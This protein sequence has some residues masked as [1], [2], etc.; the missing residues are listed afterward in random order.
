MSTTPSVKDQPLVTHESAPVS[1]DLV[2]RTY[3]Y[4]GETGEKKLHV[5]DYI[6]ETRP[7]Y[8]V[9]HLRKL[10]FS[11]FMITLASTNAGFDGSLLNGLQSLSLWGSYMGDPTG[12]R[13][14]AIA[15]GYTFGCILSFAVAAWLNDRIGRVKTMMFGSFWVAVGG[16]LQGATTS[17]TTQGA[18]AM[19]LIAR[20]IMGF[21]GAIASVAAPTLLSEISYPTHREACT[22]SY[23]ICWY[24]GASICAIVTYITKEISS[25]WQWR[26]PAVLQAFFPLCQLAAWYVIPESPRFLIAKGRHEEAEKILK[27]IHTGNS[28]NPKDLELVRFEMLTIDEAIRAERA[29]G[30]SSSYFDFWTKKTYRKRLF[31]ILFTGAITQLSGNG[32]VS[33][34]LAKVLNS[35]GI[36][37]TNEQLLINMCLMIYNFVICVVCLSVVGYFK[38]RTMLL[39]CTIGMLCS[40]VIWTAISAVNQQTNFEHKSLGKAVLAMIF[41]YYACYNFGA[42][43]LPYLYLTE[44]LPYSHRSKGI[45]VF[46]FSIQCYLVYNGYVNPIAMDAIDWKYYIVYCCTLAVEV[47][48]VY[49]FYPE[50]SGR[51]LEEVAEVFG[52]LIHIS[53][54]TYSQY[55][56]EKVS[57]N[58][59]E[60]PTPIHNENV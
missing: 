38:R 37:E 43:G 55:S 21:G 47:F 1:I 45:N 50:T 17:N 20:I 36:T 23:N 34:Y 48:V 29:A 19:F 13:L 25:H 41:L 15:N 6:T 58:H 8:Q 59:H 12:Q 31:L 14:G 18:Y 27:E 3:L 11:V 28:D 54:A 4:D 32:L 33:Y 49:F 22:F 57:A 44:I 51:S 7:W 42:N 9:P 10:V 39:S 24:L 46:S 52:D 30:E 35:I 16:I 2:P 40:F 26:V 60:K 53:P 5:I 56:S